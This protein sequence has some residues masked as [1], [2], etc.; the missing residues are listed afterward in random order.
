MIQIFVPIH[1]H[2]FFFYYSSFNIYGVQTT[3]STEV[4]NHAIT[5]PSPT[6]GLKDTNIPIFIQDSKHSNRIDRFI[7]KPHFRMLLDDFLQKHVF[8]NFI[9]E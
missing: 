4:I 2:A 1:I 8:P 7:T 9:Q 3:S 6:N 5:L